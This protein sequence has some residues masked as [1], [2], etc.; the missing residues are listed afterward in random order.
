MCIRDIFQLVGHV[1]HITAGY[2]PGKDYMGHIRRVCQLK[3]PVFLEDMQ[4]D[5]ILRTAAFVRAT[6]Q[7]RPN[8]T[9]YWPY[10]YAMILR[11]NPSV[12]ASLAKFAPDKVGWAPR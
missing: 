3:A 4:Q 12:R 2:K 7:G 6:M 5:R 8:A 11:R 1:E 10:L 9:E